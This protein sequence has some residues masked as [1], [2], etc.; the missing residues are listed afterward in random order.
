MKVDGATGIRKY[1][2]SPHSL[3][4]HAPH[5]KI[6]AL[7]GRTE[8]GAGIGRTHANFAERLAGRSAGVR[9]ACRLVWTYL[10]DRRHIR[11]VGKM[12][13]P[14]G[15]VKGPEVNLLSVAE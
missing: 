3:S 14:E 13:E 5:I 4:A 7:C 10:P 15:V 11:L 1:V 12:I 8:T 9:D 2:P 6:P